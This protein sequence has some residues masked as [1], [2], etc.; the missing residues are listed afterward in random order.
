MSGMDRRATV[1]GGRAAF[2]FAQV[3]QHL[4]QMTDTDK[5]EFRSYIKRMPSMIQVNGLAQTLAFY[6]AKQD[7]M[8]KVYS[9]LDEW[10]KQSL[11]SVQPARG[12][13]EFVEWVVTLP[14]T[15]YKI[16]AV[17]VMALLN[18]MCRFADGLIKGE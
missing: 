17:E 2:A 15:Q 9:V 6:F 4:G 16:V 5:K 1:E 13:S 7:N 12:S 8:G 10:A 18:W 3:K 14:S 11:T